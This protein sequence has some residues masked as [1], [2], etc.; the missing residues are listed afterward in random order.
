MTRW[1]SIQ[2]RELCRQEKA[3]VRGGDRPELRVLAVG[4]RE[5]ASEVGVA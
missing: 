2:L 3:A 4:V 1:P 5:I